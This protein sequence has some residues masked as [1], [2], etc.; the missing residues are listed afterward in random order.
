MPYR[1]G[2]PY[3]GHHARMYLRTTMEVREVH[4]PPPAGLVIMEPM[5]GQQIGCN[6]KWGLDLALWIPTLVVGRNVTS[7]VAMSSTASLEV[8]IN[9]LSIRRLASIKGWAL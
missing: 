7:F 6:G 4:C 8:Y 3:R 5:V 1:V 2:S 9:C